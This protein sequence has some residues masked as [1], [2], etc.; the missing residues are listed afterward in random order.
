MVGK[1]QEPNLV[2][3]QHLRRLSGLDLTDRA[4]RILGHPLDAALTGSEEHH[5]N[6]IAALTV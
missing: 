6:G 3:F 2:D 5:V 4:Y 1:A